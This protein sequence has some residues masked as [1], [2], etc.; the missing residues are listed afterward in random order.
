[1]THLSVR[2]T[3]V[4]I[5]LV[6][7]GLI[8]I[9]LIAFY[10]AQ[11]ARAET[12][13]S[14]DITQNATWSGQYRVTNAISLKSGVRLIIQPGTVIYFD[15]YAGI[16]CYG[17]LLSLGETTNPVLFSSDIGNWRG[18]KFLDDDPGYGPSELWGT[19]I[20]W[21][22]SQGGSVMVDNAQVTI[23][24]SEIRQGVGDGVL[25]YANGI[26]II[27]DTLITEQLGYALRFIDPSVDQHLARL[28]ATGNGHDVIALSGGGS[29]LEADRLWEN[30]GLPYEI[31][32][33][34]FSVGT[35][36]TL[37]I[38]PG[39]TM[40]FT[41]NSSLSVAGRLIAAGTPEMPI[42]FT[43]ID[44]TPGTWGGINIIGSF[45]SPATA[46]VS[47]A[48][49][50]YGGYGSAGGNLRVENARAAIE[51][52]RIQYGGAYG[53]H[54]ANG[55]LPD[56]HYSQISD[57]A[58]GGVKTLRAD[59]PVP[60]QNNWWGDPS[61]PFHP[62]TNPDGLG[63]SVSDNV[64]YDPWLTDPGLAGPGAA[65]PA[66]LQVQVIGRPNF[67]PGSRQTYAI[68]YRNGTPN[69]ITDAVL[70]V[71]LPD[72]AYY[73][74]NEGSGFYWPEREQVFWRLGS[75]P[76]DKEGIVAVTVEYAWG[77]PFGSADAVTAAI[78]GSNASNDLI[79]LSDYL[80]YTP[81]TVT[82]TP[83]TPAQVSALLAG[84]AEADQLYN[85]AING[86]FR[87]IDAYA[88]SRSDGLALH[89][90]NLLHLGPPLT[91]Q[92]IMVNATSATARSFNRDGYTI[93][94]GNS[95]NFYDRQTKAWTDLTPGLQSTSFWLDQDDASFGKCMNNCM[96]DMLKSKII[97]KLIPVADT[98]SAV[99]DC[100]AAAN[101]QGNTDAVLGCGKEIGSHIPIIGDAIDYGTEVGQCNS[102]CQSDPNSHFCTEDK[103]ECNSG[104]SAWWNPAVVTRKCDKVTGRYDPPGEV[105]CGAPGVSSC[106]IGADGK[107]RCNNCF[108]DSPRFSPNPNSTRLE[109][110]MSQGGAE[111][112]ATLAPNLVRRNDAYC[113]YC[114]FAKDPNAKL[115]MEGLAAP[116]QTLEFT[117]QFE[118]VGAGEAYGVFVMDHLAA[119]FDETTLSLGGSGKYLSGSRTIVWD[120]GE[121]APKGQP[122]SKGE[123]TFTVQ[124]R[125]DL[126]AGSVVVNQATVYFPSVPEVT[127]TNAVA[128]IIQPLAGRDQ[129]VSTTV[130]QPVAFTLEGFSASGGPLTFTVTQPPSFGDLSGTPPNLTYTPMPGFAGDDHLY[131]TVSSGLETSLPAQVII[132]VG[133]DPDDAAAPQLIASTPA[134]GGVVSPDTSA[135]RAEFSE[136][137]ASQSVTATAVRLLYGGQ[138]VS[139]RLM[140]DTYSHSVWVILEN[141]LLPGS[142]V[143]QFAPPLSDLAGNPLTQTYR[144]NF[145][146]GGTGKVYLPVI[147]R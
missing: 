143:L 69:T 7:I 57:N 145:T 76:P 50:E 85:Q 114:S 124:L 107:P 25:G 27:S 52:S 94:T 53:L 131:F 58:L 96:Q 9:S 104:F 73:L 47:Y 142:Y 22:G 13:V 137:I 37:T 35:G 121:L 51:Y 38:E 144:I 119:E 106:V 132:G 79:L 123:F 34:G 54:V 48:N 101:D 110:K 84:N 33:T 78:A 126:S 93:L 91:F 64:L 70:V 41:A 36:E 86:G 17:Q 62:A 118:N 74:N 130:G 3:S 44:P 11:P 134:N 109:L 113:P 24:N 39:V 71:F 42:T 87:F 28:Q 45:A 147:S 65:R 60:A 141:S 20:E 125:S 83:L 63:N 72:F 55:G 49:I 129:R 105:S 5:R 99:A 18:L 95:E 56:I 29:S 89:E 4:L 10:P 122:G 117:V 97:E 103:V 26:A 136:A 135:L 77:I 140:V 31:L 128:N 127:P 139:T 146:V 1:M 30:A 88:A 108:A 23:A 6:A 82:R 40:R 67:V 61:G 19:I 111:P 12:I 43:G 112:N 66:E 8:L 138:A 90:I 102:D 16:D 80:N 59:I 120:V 32:G 46:V 115:G 2:S 100:V 116:G 81:P 68:A 75:L 14:S 21:G 15:P 133:P 98:A 92:S